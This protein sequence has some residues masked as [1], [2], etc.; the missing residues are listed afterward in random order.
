M[1]ALNRNDTVKCEDCGKEFRR[2]DTARHSGVISCLECNYCTYNQQE[3]NFHTSKMHMKSTPKSTKCLLYEKEIPSYYSLEQHCKKDHGLKVRKTSDFVADLNKILENEKNSD[4]IRDEL[5]ACQH[6][7]TDTEM[8]N[9]RH[10]VFNF[11]LS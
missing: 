8:E 7:L 3:M 1:P 5:N 11:Q 4:Q 2:S 6:F 9:G 10:K